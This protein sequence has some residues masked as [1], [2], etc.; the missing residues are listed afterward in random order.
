M[1]KVLALVLAVVMVCTMAMAVSIKDVETETT[2]PE[3]TSSVYTQVTPG[4]AIAISADELGYSNGTFGVYTDKGEF[5]PA[6]N[7][8]VVTFEKGSEL[9]ASQGWVKNSVDSKY[10][11]LLTTKENNYAALDEKADIV[12]TKIVAKAY[13]TKTTHDFDLKGTTE[14]LKDA[15]LIVRDNDVTL[16]NTDIGWRNLDGKITIA[17]VT[18]ESTGYKFIG[19]FDYGFEAKTE[20]ISGK[21]AKSTYNTPNTLLTVNKSAKQADGKFYSTAVWSLTCPGTNDVVAA[22]TMKAGETL[23]YY[24]VSA[25]AAGSAAD[26][27]LKKNL[28]ANEAEILNTLVGVVPD[29]IVEVSMENAPETAKMYMVKADGSV[30]DLGAK[31][32]ADGVLVASAKLT[33]PVIVTDKAITAASAST[34][35]TTNPGTGANDV[36]GVAAALAVVA[37]VSGAAISLKK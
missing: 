15:Y 24:G 3:V 5:V 35:T 13:G 11:Y 26:K 6:K 19:V 30:V 27:A 23:F 4:K 25:P 14:A 32:D 22:R 29:A 12:I 17:G 28:N 21:N 36:V 18:Y 33:G 34:G 10:Y 31:F 37:L 7:P 1:K 8:V 9:I 16:N 20:T 2:A